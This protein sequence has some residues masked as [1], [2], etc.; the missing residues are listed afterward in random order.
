M[1]DDGR[2]AL[3][4][5]A[6]IGNVFSPY[7]ARRRRHGGAEALDH[8]ALN[9]AIYG[10]GARWALTERGRED[11]WRSAHR[12]RIGPSSV[13]WDGRQLAIDIDEW[14]VPVPRRVRG[15]VLLTPLALTDFEARLDDQGLHRWRPIAPSARVEVA[16]DTPSVRWA[17]QGY[18]DS[19]A[20]GA[21]LE[22][23]FD[24]WDWMRAP[25]GREATV[26]YDVRRRDGSAFSLA[27]RFDASGRATPFAPPAVVTLPPT[28]WGIARDCRAD[29]AQGAAV[30]RTLEDT[31]FYARSLVRAT[32]QG[33][34]VVAVHESLDLRRFRSPWV[35]GLLPFRLP[36]ALRP[37][38]QGP[39]AMPIE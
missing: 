17:G 33:S 1:S 12:L 6:L 11:L 29:D 15:R 31:P 3:T 38:P 27:A 14:C 30:T 18:W 8:V 19:N 10:D 36:R 28:A 26:T 35:Q 24:D 22:E 7:Y 34:E 9:V 4:I 37:H 32:L 25:I 20:G 2:N 39:R 23:A 5:I 21:P 13:R 16:L